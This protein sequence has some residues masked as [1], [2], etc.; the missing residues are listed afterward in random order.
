[1]ERGKQAEL[2]TYPGVEHEFDK[3][4][5]P[6]YNGQVTADAQARTL[7]FLAARLK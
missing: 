4:R 3:I 1:L 2:V 7:A 6:H 5:S